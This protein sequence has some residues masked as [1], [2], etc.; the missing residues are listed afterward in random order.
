MKPMK[1]S[2]EQV[3]EQGEVT[4]QL[5]QSMRADPAS[6][7]RLASLIYPELKRIASAHMRHERP[8]H[9]LQA[10]ALV[11]ELYL[12][13]LRRSE[14][15]WTSRNHFL[16]AASQAMRRLLVDHAR[17]KRSQKRGGAAGWLELGSGFEQPIE[18]RTIEVLQLDELITR[19]ADREP[20]MATVVELKFFGGLTF[21][22]IGAVLGADERTA[23]RDWTLARAWLR[24][25]LGSNESDGMGEN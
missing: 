17:A 3:S 14:V 21:Q 6:R 13:L 18:N 11:N 20:R 10:T 4:A 1:K 15:A 7:E 23:K 19:L 9:T 5:N 12:Q 22:E 25:Q 2:T 8:D 24:G 16:L